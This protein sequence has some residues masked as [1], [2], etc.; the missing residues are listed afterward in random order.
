[1]IPH[2][3]RARRPFADSDD[4]G[5]D[6]YKPGYTRGPLRMAQSIDNAL[7]PNTHQDVDKFGPHHRVHELLMSLCWCQDIGVLVT[8]RDVLN[9]RTLSCGQPGC[10]PEYNGRSRRRKWTL[11]APAR[12][13][14][15]IMADQG[16][17]G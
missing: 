3:H 16:E 11:R 15:E 9:G 2:R 14:A 8:P 5:R 12:S 4:T 6:E 1:M 10:T 13:M 7:R 17:C